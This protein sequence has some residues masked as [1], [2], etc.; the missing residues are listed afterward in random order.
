[1]FNSNLEKTHSSLRAILNT[2]LRLLFITFFWATESLAMDI[3]CGGRFGGFSPED[4]TET[5]WGTLTITFEDCEHAIA[6]LSGA[7]G[8]QTMNIVKLANLQ[9]S[10]LDCP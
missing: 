1:M 4:I 5:P 9:G 7:D 10:D 2:L 6:T 3:S 8:Q